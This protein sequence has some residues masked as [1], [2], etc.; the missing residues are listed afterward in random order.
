MRASRR[1]PGQFEIASG[2]STSQRDPPSRPVAETSDSAGGERRPHR[3]S[4]RVELLLQLA[5]RELVAGVEACASKS[6]ER[7]G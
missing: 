6:T 1:V 5:L 7:A 3:Q 2:S 4:R